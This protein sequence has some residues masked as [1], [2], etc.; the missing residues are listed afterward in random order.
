V[1]PG[2]VCGVPLPEGTRVPADQVVENYGSGESGEDTAYHFDLR[3]GDIRGVI[4]CA[5]VRDSV[6]QP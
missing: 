6:L 3:P 1:I 4:A 5:A 2:K